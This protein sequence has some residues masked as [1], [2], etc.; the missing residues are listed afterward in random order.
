MNVRI[1]SGQYGG[2]RLSTPPGQRTHPMS[3]RARNAL[4]NSLGQTVSNASVL[5]AFAG[6]GVI[7][8]ECLS[9][10]ANSL[11]LV[12]KDRV[13]AS[14]IRDNID[15]LNAGDKASL[16][17]SPLASW[18]QSYQGDNFDL[19]IADPPYHNTQFSTVHK[20]FGL[21]K[22]GGTM[23][24]SH[25]GKGEVPIQCGIVVVD[26]RRYGNLCLTFFRREE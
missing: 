22:P 10:G 7:G 26:N 13:A 17:K 11:V 19:I 6:S 12:E 24:L 20:L 8:L 18:I 9:R 5:D 2:R 21:L 14:C 3:E 1:I 23:I 4:F 16:V 15:L 25:P